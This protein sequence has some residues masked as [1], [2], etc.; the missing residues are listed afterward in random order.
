MP[1]NEQSPSL[2]IYEGSSPQ[3]LAAVGRIARLFHEIAATFDGMPYTDGIELDGRPELVL[4]DIEANLVKI[5]ARL[6]LH[7]KPC[8]KAY[9]ELDKF[10]SALSGLA[11]LLNRAMDPA[12]DATPEPWEKGE[13]QNNGD[14]QRGEN[15]SYRAGGSAR[16]PM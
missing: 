14:E 16:L 10:K 6:K 2:N 7:R 8:G 11:Y 13:Q 4:A 5:L 12:D 1:Q 3:Y 9:E 15:E